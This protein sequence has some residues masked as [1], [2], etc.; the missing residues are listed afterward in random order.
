VSEFGV[1]VAVVS[2]AL[3]EF[4]ERRGSDR[5]AVGGYVGGGGG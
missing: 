2:E 3:D 1:M 4:Y 5:K